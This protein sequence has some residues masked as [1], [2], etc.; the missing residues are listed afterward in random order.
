MELTFNS[1]YFDR[2]QPPEDDIVDED[3]D[4]FCIY[5]GCKITKSQSRYD[6]ICLE[7]LGD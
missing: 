1:E 5:C 4:D 3:D 2:D 6:L 7:C